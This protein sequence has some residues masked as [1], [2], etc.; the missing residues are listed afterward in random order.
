MK[1]KKAKEIISIL[2]SRLLDILYEGDHSYGSMINFLNFLEEDT[3]YE[4]KDLKLD[5]KLE[6]Y[7]IRKVIDSFGPLS[8]TNQLYG[9]LEPYYGDFY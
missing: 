4:I 2:K 3:I 6:I 7:Y 8:E 9:I 1:N 5:D